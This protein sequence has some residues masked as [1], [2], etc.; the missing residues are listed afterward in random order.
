MVESPPQV[1]GLLVPY[2]AMYCLDYLGAVSGFAHVTRSFP[3]LR[4]LLTGVCISRTYYLSGLGY[5]DILK[6]SLVRLVF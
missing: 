2:C 6:G 3:A 5:Q 1:I 4:L